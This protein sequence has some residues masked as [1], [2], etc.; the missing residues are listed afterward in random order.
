MMATETKRTRR[1][2]IRLSEDIVNR[3]DVI[4]EQ[5]G[6]AT[7]TVASYAI[8]EYVNAKESQRKRARA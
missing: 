5:M 6:L 2:N 1:I 4:A 3:L 8:G 7:S